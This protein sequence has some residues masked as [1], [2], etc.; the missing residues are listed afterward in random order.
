MKSLMII[1]TFLALVLMTGSIYTQDAENV[2]QVGRIYNQWDKVND[3]VV[4]DNLAY[5]AAG[6]SGLQIVDVSNPENP[7]HHPQQK[8]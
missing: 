1:F 4:V 6:Y 3:V 5:V 8:Q 2:E 7:D